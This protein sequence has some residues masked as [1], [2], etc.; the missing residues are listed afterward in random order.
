MALIFSGSRC[1]ICEKPL[2]DGD[3]GYLATSG[4]FFEEDDPLWRFCDAGLHWD[5]YENWPERPRFARRYVESHVESLAENP[6]WGLALLT[7]DVALTVRRKEPGLVQL[8]LIETGTEIEVPLAEWSEWLWGLTLGEQEHDRLEVVNVWKALPEL[9]RR[10][11]T[12]Q[13]VLYAV[14]WAA[15]EHLA[16]ALAEKDAQTRRVWL[17][18]IQ[19]HNAACYRLFAARGPQ[20][21]I[22]PHC[23]RQSTDIEF[24]E[25]SAHERKS[26]FI[27]PAC[28]RSFGHDL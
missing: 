1:A 16:Q 19:A 15:K 6:Y 18:A 25:G 22:C 23:H 8:W 21:L 2:R 7:D 12:R 14:D 27:C 11:P 24:V 9:R 17:Q 3:R 26:C 13:S 10:F 20:G 5:C 28:G 4:V